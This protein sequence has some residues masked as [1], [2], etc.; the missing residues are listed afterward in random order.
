MLLTITKYS[1]I[2]IEDELEV[3]NVAKIIKKE[4]NKK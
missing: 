1:S 4:H 3:N 2:V